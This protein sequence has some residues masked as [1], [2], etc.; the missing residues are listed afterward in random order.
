PAAEKTDANG[1]RNK[2]YR[3][4]NHRSKLSNWF[5]GDA[6]VPPTRAEIEAGQAHVAHDAALEAPLHEHEEADVMPVPFHGGVLHTKGEP[7]TNR[8]QLEERGGNL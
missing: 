3:R 4:E 1:V 7:P 6:I 8:E 5:Y 2:R